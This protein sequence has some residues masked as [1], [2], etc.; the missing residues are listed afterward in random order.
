MSNFLPGNF[1]VL[2]T[3]GVNVRYERFVNEATA[4]DQHL[5]LSVL[6]IRGELIDYLRGRRWEE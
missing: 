6:I 5:F 1:T 4:P 2:G 3:E